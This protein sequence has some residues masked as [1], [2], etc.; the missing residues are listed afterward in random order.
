[1]NKLITLATAVAL[2]GAVS[3]PVAATPV[4]EWSIRDPAGDSWLVDADGY[5]ASPD[6]VEGN[7]HSS[8]LADIGGRVEVATKFRSLLRGHRVE[9]DVD[10]LTESRGFHLSLIRDGA[11]SMLSF[12]RANGEV[13]GCGM[14]ETAPRV[15]AA[16]NYRYD[17][18][19]V[20]IPTSCLGNPAFV[21]TR[22]T[23][24]VFAGGHHYVDVAPGAG[25]R[26]SRMS[27]AVY[28]G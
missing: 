14:G 10:L 18:A 22:V 17:V 11:A 5:A 2:A 12:T 13:V 7:I 9:Y 27:R 8:Y 3:A 6:V 24:H 1:M 19:F 4:S 23:C 26:A 28:P 20:I 16:V 21:R 15:R 25:P